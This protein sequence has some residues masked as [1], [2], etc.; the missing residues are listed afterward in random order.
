M[1]PVIQL[2]HQ[3]VT[4]DNLL[5]L[6]SQYRLLPQLLRESIIDQAIA[7]FTCT[8]EE[9]AAACQSFYQQYQITEAEQQ[10]WRTQY[11]LTIE[12]VQALATRPLKVE[13]F[14]LATWGNKL[15][16][17][18]LS[19]KE[20]FDRVIYSMIRTKDLGIA[21]ELFFR[22][23]AGE[24]SLS[25]LAQQYSQ[26]PEAQTSGLV[27]PAEIGSLHPKLAHVLRAS[28]P[29]KL[30]PPMAMGDWMVIVRLEKFIPVQLDGP[31]QQRL[32][33]ELFETWLGEQMAQLPEAERRW[34]ELAQPPRAKSGEKPI[35]A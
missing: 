2:S 17:Y 12:Q 18:F 11:G 13:K 23:E 29:G 34:L 1:N 16:S 3:T 10:D 30:W 21:Q 19:R 28:Q 35:A 31:M 25:E 15:G 6:L 4:P 24:Q 7:P 14:K 33:R 32:L 9:T 5:P 22:I 26:G 27:G 20:Q 8:A